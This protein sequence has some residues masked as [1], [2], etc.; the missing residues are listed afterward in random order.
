[1]MAI[2]GAGGG[3]GGGKGGSKASQRTPT[4]KANS[5]FSTSYAELVDL[6]GEG[7]IHGLVDGFK[8]IFIDNTPLQNADGSYNFKN[9]TVETRNGTD[10]NTQDYIRGFDDISSEVAVGIVVT[11]AAP[12]TRTVA[13]LNSG[14]NA[15]RLTISVPALQEIKDNGD[16]A[17]AKI[18]LAVSIQ[19]SGSAGFDVVISDTISGR[20]SQLYQKQYTVELTGT[21][22]AVIKVTRQAPDSGSAKLTNAF[23]WASFTQV[24]YAKL[25]YPNSA[26]VG[27]RIDS[28][29]FNSIPSR[30]YRVRGLKIRIPN[31]GT[32][33]QTTGAITYSG[34]W[35]GTFKAAEWCSDPAWCL[36]D[37]LT[38][39]YGFAGHLDANSL[40]K[41]SFYAASQYCG[42][43]V[44]NG[45]GGTE[46]RFSC[47]VN[48]QTEQ[49]AYR[50]IADMASVFR[51][52][53]FWSAGAMAISQDR[54][55]DPSYLFNYSNVSE[56][57]FTYSGSSVK[58]RPT[59]AV[60]SY[61]DLNQRNTAVEVVEDR[62]GIARYGII[63]TEVGAFGCTSRGQAYRLGEWL[64]YSSQ[65]ER[66]T[67]SF[68]ASLDASLLRPG[69]II[70][71]LDPMRAGLR[72]GGKISAATTTVVTVDDATDLGAFTASSTLSVV[73][74]TGLV[75]FRT[76]TAISGRNITVSP[77]FSS[78]PN[79]NSVWVYETPSLQSTAWR[80]LS[81]VEQDECQ[82]AITA[83]AHNYGKYAY[84]ERGVALQSRTVSVLNA[85]PPAPASLTVVEKLYTNADQV[86][87]KVIATWIGAAGINEY[88]VKWRKDEGNWTTV[89]RQQQ[90]FE[91]LDVTP[92]YFEF[93]VYSLN[94]TGVSST[95]ALSG[96]LTT[97]GKT[98]PPSNVT[99]FTAILDPD[100]GV[101][102]SWNAVDDLD[103]LCYQIYQSEN[104]APGIKLGEFTATSK[105]L[106]IPVLG[107]TTWTII[108]TDTSYVSSLL[109]TSTSL[110][111]GPASAPT[112]SGLI[113]G[114]VFVLTWT[115]GAGSLAT[116]YSDV[117]YGT[118]ASTYAAATPLATV[119]G[120]TQSVEVDWGG[121][122]RFFVAAVDTKGNYGA[123]ATYDAVVAAPGQPAI[124]QQVIDNNVLLQWSDA[125]AT[126]TLPIVVYELRKG[127]TWASAAYIGTKQG[128]FT[129]VF[130]FAAGTYTYWLAGIDS[131]GNYGTPGS[132]SAQ[133]S[134]PPDYVLQDDRNSTFAGYKLNL[135]P[136]G[137]GNGLLASVSTTET[138]QSHFTIRSWTTP[139]QQITAGFPYFAQPSQTT[140][141]YVE[142]PIDYGAVLV[143]QRIT[144]TLT[145]NNVAGATVV[146]PTLY[147][148]GTTTTSAT[149]SRTTTT[150]TV[151]STAHGLVAGRLVNLN[152][153][154]GGAVSGDYFVV[155]AA[156][157][158]FTVTTAAT[159]T[160]G[161][162]TWIPWTTYA[163][164]STA[165]ATNF[166]Y[167][168]VQYD[169]SSAGGDDL[170]E[171][172]ALN[173]RLDTKLRN[174]S[175]NGVA[176]APVAAT[177]SQA[178]TVITVTSTA[179]GLANGQ[180]VHLAFTSGT[181]TSGVYTVGGAAA[182]TFTVTS[183]T[184]TTTSGNVTLHDGGTVVSFNYP[185]IDVASIAVTPA[186]T[187][188]VIAVY[189]FVDVANPT[190]FKVLL[191]NTAGT[192]VSGSFSWSA[193]GV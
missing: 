163:N 192:R 128:R 107:T 78:V 68:T 187:S 174:D 172:T 1:M 112:T 74:S 43:S 45:F 29:Q 83:L 124:T 158:T 167:L 97:V 80:V 148:R 71:V 106:G 94:I 122:R 116:D 176:V 147:T 69:A 108:A 75:E 34:V 84:V 42:A 143:G 144:A 162:V 185:F 151:T 23:S 166:R 20:T 100:V 177:Y 150:V 140:G 132:V 53:P 96:S 119:K 95:A 180:L 37:L 101:T 134:Q 59:V 24:T 35:G 191:F 161:N 102:L 153:T 41:W 31:N 70:E 88:L 3:G 152:F 90:D 6:I 92:G 157:N 25:R 52:M 189:D 126:G 32:V 137:L 66:Q 121:T 170:L 87:S 155:T 17:G 169:F 64:L 165:F 77:G 135:A 16:I 115:A 136:T 39:R 5:L 10:A 49:D 125:G 175:G 104:G 154:T 56:E 131:A 141:Q 130:E 61:M 91:I 44:S 142:G 184:S 21:L 57:G 105:K 46:P 118:T 11:Q 8:S 12:V 127:A 123:A 15:I 186:A 138:W 193:R 72:R 19:Y 110:T 103:I 65:N 85:A 76:V 60:V 7:E 13:A 114:G 36:W 86:R 54:P 22:P 27:I 79:G 178:T 98:A 73:L 28:E 38:A 120:T 33:N 183:A 58:A 113:S 26:L 18:F 40:D 82:Y 93:D 67:I 173:I 139:Q 63:K 168:R 179:H 117:R 50:L 160:S 171:L 188:A 81:V 51:A 146:T 9:V 145:S 156:A 62:A 89:S 109:G 55:A 111:V 99:G 133:V 4:E 14:V 30:S 159:G 164:V 129:T 182:N 2:S 181:A 47:N 190:S 48:I 149:Y